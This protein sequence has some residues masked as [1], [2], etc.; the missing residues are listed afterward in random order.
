V[1]LVLVVL[2]LVVLVL[3]VLVLVVLVL[4]VLVLVLVVLVL[5][6]LVLVLVV[7]SGFARRGRLY[8]P[9]LGMQDA[10]VGAASP[11]GRGGGGAAGH[12]SC[13]PKRTEKHC[14]CHA[15]MYYRSSGVVRDV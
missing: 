15:K 1:V 8:I 3:V 7:A 10:G 6:V 13:Y 2:V 5:V 9:L 11:R 4:V 14:I 12:E